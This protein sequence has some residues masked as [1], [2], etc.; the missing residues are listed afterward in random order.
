MTEVAWLNKIRGRSGSRDSAA[1][2]D[3]VRFC[4]LNVALVRTRWLIAEEGDVRRVA[5]DPV[6]PPS[7]DLVE[8]AEALKLLDQLVRSDEG[9]A[10]AVLHQV[11]VHEWPLEEEV[12]KPKAVHARGPLLNQ[13]SVRLLELEDRASRRCS[14][15]RCL[16]NTG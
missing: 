11:H 12:E 6:A 7:C 16:C 3:D 14:L 8:D 5:E 13:T 10:K 9:D 4:L 2:S 1:I 15:L